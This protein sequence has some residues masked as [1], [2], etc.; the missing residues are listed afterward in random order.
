[1]KKLLGFILG[2]AL[3]IA[4]ISFGAVTTDP[5]ITGIGGGCAEGADCGFGNMTATSLTTSGG[6][7]AGGTITGDLVFADVRVNTPTIRS[8]TQNTT[9]AVQTQAFSS[10][11][12]VAVNLATGAI[13][14][15]SGT[16]TGVQ[17][18]PT[19]DQPTGT[20]SNTDFKINRIIGTGVG[21]GTQLSIDAQ[22]D[23]V[24]MF[25]VDTKGTLTTAG[26]LTFS[27]ISSISGTL[28]MADD[29]PVWF[30]DCDATGGDVTVTLPTLADNQGKLIELRRNSAT[31]DCIFDGE[32]GEN[33]NGQ[34]TKS[35]G[36]QYD[37]IGLLA[38]PSEWMIR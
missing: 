16:F 37:V 4:G 17:I 27:G 25:S 18:K 32:G 38:G 20:A 21:S 28:T 7:T 33:I 19:Y 22:V 35:T 3:L 8:S 30:Y 13:T 34:L 10:P 6:I 11:N 12:K 29:E 1:M 2:G 5:N 36:I 31:N 26:G 24:S 9:L 15:T 14:N 23:N